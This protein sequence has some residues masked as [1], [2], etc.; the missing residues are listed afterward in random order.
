MSRRVPPPADACHLPAD[1]HPPSGPVS[2]VASVGWQNPFFGAHQIRDRRCRNLKLATR[3]ILPKPGSRSLTASR[4]GTH[5]L[6]GPRR[7][8]TQTTQ[9]PLPACRR[10]A[11]SACRSAPQWPMRTAKRLRSPSPDRA[12]TESRMAA[13]P[14]GSRLPARYLLLIPAGTLAAVMFSKT[15]AL[16]GDPMVAAMFTLILAIPFACAFFRSPA[17]NRR[18]S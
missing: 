3:R 7:A 16:V 15:S 9:R 17:N 18:R 8:M 14:A 2:R 13:V 11:S 10:T 1:I 5:K 6:L 12:Q 4:V